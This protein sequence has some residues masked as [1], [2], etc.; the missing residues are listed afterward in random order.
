MAKKTDTTFEQQ[1]FKP[2]LFYFQLVKSSKTSP[3]F[4]SIPFEMA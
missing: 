3:P 4:H 2:P 1:L